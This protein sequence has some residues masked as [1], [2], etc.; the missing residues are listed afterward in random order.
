MPEVSSS[1][2]T[3]LCVEY[4][5]DEC[6]LLQKFLELDGYRI[7][8]ASSPQE[9]LSILRREIVE[10]CII[11]RHLPSVDGLALSKIIRDEWK[12]LVIILTTT[13]TRPHKLTEPLAIGV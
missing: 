1:Q 7:L 2:R 5:P 3:V 4:N 12:D 10:V 13:D 9:A 8:T 6:F 11:D